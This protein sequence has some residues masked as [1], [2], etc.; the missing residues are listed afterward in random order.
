MSLN[1]SLEPSLLR[2]IEPMTLTDFFFILHQTSSVMIQ[3]LL[4]SPMGPA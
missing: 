4:G 1:S 3:A 2:L